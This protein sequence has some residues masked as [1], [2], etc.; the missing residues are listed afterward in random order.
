MAQ[1]LRLLMGLSPVTYNGL[2]PP[3]LIFATLA[4][5]DTTHVLYFVTHK[6]TILEPNQSPEYTI[7]PFQLLWY[8]INKH[9]PH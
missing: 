6:T 2:Q 4:P 8:I 5:S 1:C 3:T 7:M 9:S